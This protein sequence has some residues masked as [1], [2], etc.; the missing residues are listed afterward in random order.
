MHA[1]AAESLLPFLQLQP[2]HPSA[3]ARGAPRVLDIGS[4]SGYLTT[5]LAHLVG[6]AGKVVG[7]E[8]IQ[9]LVDMANKNVAKSEDGRAMLQSGRLRFVKGDGRLGFTDHEDGDNGDN[10]DDTG[11]GG[12]KGKGKGYW[13]A[14]HVGA[15]AKE[16]HKE[17]VDQL[18]APGRLFI[19]VGEDVQHIWVIDKKVDGSVV[20]EKMYGVRYVPLTDAPPVK[21]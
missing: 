13:D 11:G 2:I 3:G 4:G 20:R 6:P 15:A 21:D 18:R 16:A 10:D 9:S 14:I 7:V 17:L 1:A 12:G 8:H 5:V 19:P